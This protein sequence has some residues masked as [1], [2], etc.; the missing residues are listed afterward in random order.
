M[1]ELLLGYFR[2]RRFDVSDFTDDD[3]DVDD[4]DGCVA[5]DGMLMDLSVFGRKGIRWIQ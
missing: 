4:V 2:R 1:H 5:V 3:D